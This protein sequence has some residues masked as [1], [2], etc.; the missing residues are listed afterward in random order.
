MEI[1]YFVRLFV[2]AA[3]LA[4]PGVMPRDHETA[5]MVW[6]RANAEAVWAVA[7]WAGLVDPAKEEPEFRVRQPSIA[8]YFHAHQWTLWVLRCKLPG[9]YLLAPRPGG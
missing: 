2:A 3:L 7:A 9:E 1:A 5:W 8:L 4:R 6:D